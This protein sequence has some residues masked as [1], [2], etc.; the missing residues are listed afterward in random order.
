VR[1]Q[2]SNKFDA[3][4]TEQLRVPTNPVSGISVGRTDYALVVDLRSPQRVSTGNCCRHQ[5]LPASLQR[6]DRVGAAPG[7][8]SEW[9]D[10]D[11]DER[12]QLQRPRAAP[13]FQ[14]LKSS[15]TEGERTVSQRVGKRKGGRMAWMSMVSLP[16]ELR[17]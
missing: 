4:V 9:H 16:T 8:R 12:C 11:R 10:M 5:V 17:R 15:V 2:A 13:R 14:C 3:A 6:L 7:K 1:R